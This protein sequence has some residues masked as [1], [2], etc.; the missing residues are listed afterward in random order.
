[1]VHFVDERVQLLFGLLA[2]LSPVEG[3]IP[4]KLR[5]ENS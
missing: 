4:V 3:Q 2:L 5:H 1:M